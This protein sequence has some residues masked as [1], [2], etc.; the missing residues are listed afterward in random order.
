MGRHFDALSAYRARPF[1]G[2]L[3]GK[4]IAEIPGMH[5][6]HIRYA[7]ILKEAHD[8]ARVSRREQALLFRLIIPGEKAKFAYPQLSTFELPG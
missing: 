5:D 1:I 8:F 4:Q 7:Q 6:P 3:R 2:K